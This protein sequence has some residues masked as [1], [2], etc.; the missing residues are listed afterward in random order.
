MA[1]NI[2]FLVAKRLYLGAIFKVHIV[3]MYTSL[4]RWSK[5][6]GSPVGR[7]SD[8]CPMDPGSIPEPAKDPSCILM[9]ADA[10]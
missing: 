9:V 5:G 6:H 4:N 8:S 2:F 10:R 1:P 3:F 7:V